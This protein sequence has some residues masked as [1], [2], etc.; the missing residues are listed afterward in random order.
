[1][2]LNAQVE[3]NAQVEKGWIQ[4]LRD[5]DP[6]MGEN[7]GNGSEPSE[8]FLIHHEESRSGERWRART[9]KRQA[10][11]ELIH[12]H[13][14]KLGAI[15]PRCHH[16]FHNACLGKLIR[17]CPLVQIKHHASLASLRETQ[18]TK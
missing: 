3:E 16:S 6:D 9:D 14:L 4:R 18:K 10:A 7:A 13:D 5:L 15:E 2:Q 17:S 1:M 11:A 8:P 12:L